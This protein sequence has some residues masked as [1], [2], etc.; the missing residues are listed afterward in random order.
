MIGYTLVGSNDL[1]RAKAFYDGLFGAIGVGR[2]MEFPTGGCAWG[3]DWSKPMFGVGKPY[4]GQAATSGNGTMIAIVLD[5]RAKVD[6]LYDKAIALGGQCEGGPGV[7]GAEG[8]QAFYAAYFR[9]L[10]GNK[11]CAFRV[12]PAN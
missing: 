9:D 2:M 11:L 8:E 1:D 12:G 5:E 6:A 4:D 10:D 3:A 7:R